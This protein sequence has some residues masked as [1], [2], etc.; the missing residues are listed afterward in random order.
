MLV[1]I[2]SLHIAQPGRP[3]WW[4]IIDHR[5]HTCTHHN[6]ASLPMP[7]QYPSTLERQKP[8]PISFPPTIQTRQCHRI[9]STTAPT[10][11]NAKTV[12]NNFT[13]PSAHLT[14]SPGLTTSATPHAAPA[15]VGKFGPL[16]IIVVQYCPFHCTLVL[17]YVG[18]AV[19]PAG[20]T[21]TAVVCCSGV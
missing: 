2:Y 11:C 17:T 16:A 7:N 4:Y 8:H 5:N 6:T 15:V 9:L 13:H 18:C 20:A 19:S 21:T 3:S 1:T 12:P 14:L 10:P